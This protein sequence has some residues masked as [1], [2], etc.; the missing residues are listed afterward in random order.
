VDIEMIAAEFQAGRLPPERMP[1]VATQLLSEGWDSPGLRL[2]AGADGEDSS[3]QRA[4]FAL[5]LAELDQLP[6][7]ADELAA[8]FTTFWAL[9]VV[10]G[11]VEPLVAARELW[12]LARHDGVQFSDDSFWA[13]GAL[14]ADEYAGPGVQEAYEHDIR[15]AASRW[16][17]TRQR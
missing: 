8:R 3:E 12:V 10:R 2:A 13:W 6:L 1:A 5:A 15:E 9:R 11:E 17:A 14:D 7:A 16:L 4:T